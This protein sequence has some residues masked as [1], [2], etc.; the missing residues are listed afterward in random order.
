MRILNSPPLQCNNNTISVQIQTPPRFL[1]TLKTN[2][3]T[4]RTLTLKYHNN[5]NNKKEDHHKKE[6]HNASYE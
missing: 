5:N 4:A 1:P 6:K 2:P 3:T